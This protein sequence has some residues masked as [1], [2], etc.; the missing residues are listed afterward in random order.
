MTITL[1]TGANKGLGFETARRLTGLGHTVYLGARDSERGKAAARSVG[2]H[3][4]QL[5]VTDDASVDDAAAFVR[6]DAGHLDVL[7]NNAGVAGSLAA[8]ADL[9]ADMV[10]NVYQTNVFGLVRVTHAMLP[11]LRASTSP[12]IVSVSNGMGSFGLVTDPA[13]P[14]FAFPAVAYGSSKAAVSALTVQYAKAL[15]EIR[16]NAVDPGYTATDL[17]GKSGTQTVQEGTDAI[18]R[19]AT[20]DAHGPTGTFSNRHGPLPW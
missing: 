13:H 20:I 17:N 4:V 10:E 9:T 18:V 3:F 16:I 6:A 8:P 14:G 19:L 12:V 1:I 5:D 15:P 2:A 11:L 7:V